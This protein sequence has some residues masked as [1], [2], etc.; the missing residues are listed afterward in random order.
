MDVDA[1]S[2]LSHGKGTVLSSPRDG[3]LKCGGA[4]R[5]GQWQAEQVVVPE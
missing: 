2:S 4:R 3:C 5:Y 1:V